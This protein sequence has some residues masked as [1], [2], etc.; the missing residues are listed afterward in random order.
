MASLALGLG[1]GAFVAAAIGSSEGRA[2]GRSVKEGGTLWIGAIEFNHIDPALAT[3]PSS[4]NPYSLAVWPA[5]D[6]TCALLLRYPV[7]PPP[8]RYNLVP[9]VATDYPAVSPD[10][11]TYTFK[12]RKGYRFSNGAPVT[13]A[14]FASA[15]NRILNPAM[16]SPAEQYLQD[17]VGA[18]AVRRGAAQTASGIKVAGDRLIVRLTRRAADFPARMTMPYF[19]PIPK[20]MPI[21]PEGAGAPIPGSGPYYIAEFVR[22]S[23]VVLEQNPYYRGPRE[24]HLD[25]LV[26]QIFD[27]RGAITQQVDAGELDVDYNP[28]NPTLPDLAAKYGVNKT[29]F[30]AL[31]SSDMFFVVMNTSRPLFKNN[32]KLRQAVNFALDRR[33]LEDAAGGKLGG[34]VTDDYLPRGMPGYVDGHLYPL[35]HPDLAKAKALARRNTRSGKA[36]LILCDTVACPQQAQIIKANLKKIGIDVDLNLMPFAVQA[37][38]KATRGQPWDLTIQRHEVDYMDPSQFVDVLLDGRRIRATRNTN[39]A[40]F[41]SDRYNRLIDHAGRLLKDDRYDTYGRLAVDLAANSAPLAALSVRNIKFLVSSRVGCLQTTAHS[42]LEL[43]GLC[44][45]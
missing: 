11:R 24:H 8:I 41:D 40:Y 34:S 42:G 12:I 27:T 6:A 45:K 3:P 9:E 43:A 22:G 15:M 30:W 2:S 35:E 26:I 37:T 4:A 23:R 1:M 44:L 29:Q 18:K 10:D 16:K 14:T 19:C 32:R 28:P 5:E 20:D 21:D 38:L 13:A 31:R 33:D 39:V 17:V 36:T 7:G 25:R